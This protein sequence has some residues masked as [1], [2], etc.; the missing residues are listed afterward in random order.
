MTLYSR[1]GCI[2]C[3]L[4][5][6]IIQAQNF[7]SKNVLPKSLSKYNFGMRLDDFTEKNKSASHVDGSI[8]F[9]VVYQQNA[10][11]DNIKKVVYYFDA[12]DNKPLYEMII[13]FADL[14]SLDA[15]CSKKLG[16]PNNG[17][18]WTWKTKEG[19]SV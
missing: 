16:P 18:E 3:L 11:G 6:F 19:H 7:N 2:L 4:F 12:D 1:A 10:P 8:D 15:H 14:Q 13:E 9:R 17:K 5:P